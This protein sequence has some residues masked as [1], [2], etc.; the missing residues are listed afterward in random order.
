MAC[1]TISAKISA[2]FYTVTSAIAFESISATTSLRVSAKTSVESAR[3]H[4]LM[5]AKHR[6]QRR[7]LV[8]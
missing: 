8:R 3:I 7:V 2:R 6:V 4:A 1:R 5:H